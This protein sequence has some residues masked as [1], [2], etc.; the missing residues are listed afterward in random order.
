MKFLYVEES[1]LDHPRT[2]EIKEKLS[3]TLIPIKRYGEVFNRHGGHFRLQKRENALIL[4]EK[5]GKLVYEIPPSYGIGAKHNYYFSHLLNCPYDC[6]YCYL[7][8]MYRSAYYVLFLNYEDFMGAI[9]EKIG[10]EKTTFFSGYDGDSLALESY[11]NFLDYF[12][13]FFEK[14]P[15]AELE[16]RTKSGNIQK[17]L[18]RP[19]VPNVV[20]AYTLSP[21]P[22]AKAFETNA[23]SLKQRIKALLKLQEKGW[24][25]GLRFDPLIHVENYQKYYAPFFKEILDLFPRPHSI[26][27]GSFRLPLS[28]FKEMK[29]VRPKEKLLAVCTQKEE[30]MT[31]K[32]GEEMVEFCRSLL[33]KEVFVC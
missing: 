16:L 32:K 17:L 31:L 26:T 19:P 33:P 30:M 6:R 21:D 18:K 24:E 22:I 11:S 15:T 8:G 29:R 9:D 14:R 1:L 12:L 23:P 4:A 13:P 5:K 2:Q 3:P 28:T 20:I 7:Q 27:L 10:N 25:I